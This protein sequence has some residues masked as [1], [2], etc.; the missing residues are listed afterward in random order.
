MIPVLGCDYLLVFTG[1]QPELYDVNTQLCCGPQLIPKGARGCCEG[2]S[3]VEE[4]QMCCGG[5]AI[6]KKGTIEYL[7]FDPK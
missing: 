7:I 2:K 1:R 5:K 4:G 3:V 6:D